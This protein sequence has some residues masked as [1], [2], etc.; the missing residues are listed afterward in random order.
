MDYVLRKAKATDTIRI[1]ELFVEMLKAIY[2][3]DDVESYETGYL[4]KFFLDK[5]DWICVAEYENNVVAFLSIEVHR[6]E[7]YIYLDD[8]SV[9]E[10]YRNKGIG[11][12]LINA[13]EKYAEEIGIVKIAF[14][15]EKANKDAYRLYSRLGYSEDVDEGNRIRMNKSIK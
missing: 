6:D 10:E 12:K 7:D 3:T 9:A 15:I 11:T 13:A 5:E 2:H 8:L 1:E 4:D 14:H